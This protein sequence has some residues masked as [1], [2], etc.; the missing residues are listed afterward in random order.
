MS[1][2][3]PD[4]GGAGTFP[5]DLGYLNAGFGRGSALAQW[6]AYTGGV[7]PFAVNTPK[8]DLYETTGASSDFVYGW[9]YPGAPANAALVDASTPFTQ[10]GPS[11]VWEFTFDTPIGFSATS[12]TGRV[13]YA[14][15]HMAESLQVPDASSMPYVKVAASINDGGQQVP[16][17]NT[18]PTGPH[19]CIPS[20]AGVSTLNEQERVGEFF[21]FDLGACAASGLPP[22]ITAP[23][24]YASETYTR[25]YCEGAVGQPNGCT[26][27]CPPNEAVV[28]R[29]FEFGSYIPPGPDDGGTWN[30]AG[31]SIVF[32]VQTGSVES[33]LGESEDAGGSAVYTLYN[34]TVSTQGLPAANGCPANMICVD[35]K[36]VIP[37]SYDSLTWL[38]VSM[39]LNPDYTHQFAPVLNSWAQV[40]DCV[41]SQ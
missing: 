29:K 39:T 19:E 14:D 17:F 33:E 16:I 32:Q 15:M 36:N 2:Y 40:Y 6:F 20:D 21:I 8:F 25:D 7:S 3:V 24:W 27:L 30:D 38:R 12:Q 22:P 37:A 11:T 35:V 5:S 13:M 34:D 1:A 26:N 10:G 18:S 28:W 41:P 31:P 9:E 23:H 4:G